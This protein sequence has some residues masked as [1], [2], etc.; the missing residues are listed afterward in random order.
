MADEHMY[1][2]IYFM[3][4]N[5]SNILRYISTDK[6]LLVPLSLDIKNTANYLSC[7]KI[8]YDDDLIY[9]IT[10]PDEML[11]IRVPKLCTQLLVENSIKFTTKS[12]KPPWKI[13]INGTITRTHWELSISDNGPGFSE[14]EIDLL[15]QKIQEVNRTGLLPYLEIS[16]MGLMNIYIRFKLIYKGSHI[17]RIRNLAQ[18]GAIVT[19]G[20]K[21]DEK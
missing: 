15:N 19:I 4:Q 21:T 16:G 3:C 17:F 6:D 2:E 8:R 18:G 7:M 9:N 1:D 13:A 10:I 12:I 20:G 5:I 11:D 14:D